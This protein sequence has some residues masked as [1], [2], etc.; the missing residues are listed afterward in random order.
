MCA[1]PF[2]LDFEEA[3]LTEQNVRD[4][5]YEEMR[6][7]QVGTCT[8]MSRMQVAH[9]CCASCVDCARVLAQT[10]RAHTKPAVREH[11]LRPHACMPA[12]SACNSQVR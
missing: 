7:Y 4:L 11:A 1:A 6:K 9:A 3:Q 8:C 2:V 12:E 5:V 10:A